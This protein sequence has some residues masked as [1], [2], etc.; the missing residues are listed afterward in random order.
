MPRHV[1]NLKF[2][3]SLYR[4]TRLLVSEISAVAAPFPPSLS[5]DLS[6]TQI[7]VLFCARSPSPGHPP[8]AGSARRSWCGWRSLYSRCQVWHWSWR[9]MATTASS[10]TSAAIFWGRRPISDVEGR[11]SESGDK[12]RAAANKM[13]FYFNKSVVLVLSSMLAI[14]SGSLDYS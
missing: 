6:P 13:K 12:V 2:F 10:S 5:D 14:T 8:G 11:G 9:A 3:C 7:S 1:Q 4:K